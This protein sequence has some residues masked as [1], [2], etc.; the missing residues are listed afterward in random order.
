MVIK[1]VINPPKKHH[2]FRAQP[3]YHDGMH[4]SSKKELKRYLE[5]KQLQEAGE[6]N[7]FLTQVPLRIPGGV[8][9]VCD[10]L[11]FWANGEETFE[12]VKGVRTDMYKVKKKL[13]EHN[14][15]I[16]IMEL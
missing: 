1:A 4:F 16:E 13:V 2:K 6:V 7:F 15:P 14:Y 5:L 12:D 8:K 9:Y 10:Y 3:Q 11:V